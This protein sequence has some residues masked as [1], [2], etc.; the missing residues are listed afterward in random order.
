MSLAVGHFVQR[1]TLHTIDGSSGLKL[2]IAA[3]MRVYS[4][5]QCQLAMVNEAGGERRRR[6]TWPSGEP[7]HCGLGKFAGLAPMQVFQRLRHAFPRQRAHVDELGALEKL[8]DRDDRDAIPG[9]PAF[10]PP[11]AE[12]R[13]HQQRRNAGH[14]QPRHKESKQG[15]QSTRG[16]GEITKSVLCRR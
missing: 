3:R 12:R 5:R 16:L 10:E 2:R 11:Q 4:G 9:E 6:V 15:L 1:A 7:G 8:R 14:Q 13:Q